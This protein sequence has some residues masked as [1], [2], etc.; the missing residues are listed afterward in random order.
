VGSFFTN[1]HVKT[2]HLEGLE[3]ALRD[4]V[5]RD[6]YVSTPLNGW[7]TV[8][9]ATTEE[10]DLA[11]L[12]RLAQ[13][14]SAAWETTV[15]GFLVI[16][17]DVLCYVL[18]DC[19]R[20]QDEYNSKPDYF[21]VVPEAERQRVAGRP[22]VLARFCLPGTSAQRLENLLRPRHERS[23]AAAH[24]PT[25]MLAK[26]RDKMKQPPR[27]DMSLGALEQMAH[28]LVEQLKAM[29]PERRSEGLSFM[30]APL[31]NPPPELLADPQSCLDDPRLKARLLAC[32]Q[33]TLQQRYEKTTRSAQSEALRFLDKEVSARDAGSFVSADDQAAQLAA[34]F[35]IESERAVVGYNTFRSS[36]D[37]ADFHRVAKPLED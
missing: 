33:Q 35:G 6:A 29:L 22:D 37:V 1:L 26:L 17:S 28:M 34:A 19:G 5:C 8:Y 25:D 13:A 14:I 36:V 16:D 27:L 31:E 32:L 10:Q 30:G 24:I 15:L 23:R 21:E 18:Y 3:E 11:E 7:V 4:I 2:E 9:D 12:H 20:A